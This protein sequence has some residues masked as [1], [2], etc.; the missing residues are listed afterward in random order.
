MY[1][2]DGPVRVRV[3]LATTPEQ[4]QRGLMWRDELDDDAG[5]LFVF[6][7]SRVRSFWMKNTPLPLDIIY[8]DRHGAIVSIAARTTPYST[9]PIPSG[10]PAQYVLEVNGGFCSDN[11][12]RSGM[13]VD[14]PGDVIEA[15]AMHRRD[16]P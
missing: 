8:I 14:L 7:R 1:G 3:E 11:G 2:A 16:A 5:M 9:A 4:Q 13:R 10:E 6:R 15:D 12:I